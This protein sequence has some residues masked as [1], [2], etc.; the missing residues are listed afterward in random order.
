MRIGI[1]YDVHRLTE[2][3]P[4]ML[5]GVEIPFPKGFQGHSDGD[6]LLHAIIDAILGALGKGDIGELFPD[7]DPKYKGASSRSL[8]KSVT[9]L[10]EGNEIK[11]IDCIF[12]SEEP[13]IGPFREKITS[14]ISE[15]LGI[16]ESR[17]NLKAK[18]NEKLGDIGR[19]LASAA[20]AAVLLEKRR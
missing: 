15:L 11:N 12:I 14:S 2:N 9:A 7:A 17:V 13:R 19:G 20:Y 5:G 18:T 6:V 8:L 10:L 4:M 1:G 3:R 16:P